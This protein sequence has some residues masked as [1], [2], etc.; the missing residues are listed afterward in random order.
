MIT[1]LAVD[2]FVTSHAAIDFGLDPAS[3]AARATIRNT[4]TGIRTNAD[5]IRIGDRHPIAGDG[6][7]EWLD[8]FAEPLSVENAD[9]GAQFAP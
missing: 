2:L 1:T 8:P 6:A 7:R 9:V 5:E 3:P 4:I